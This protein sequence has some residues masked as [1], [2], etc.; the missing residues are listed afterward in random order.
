[1]ACFADINVSQG[2]VAT[3][4]RSDGIFNTSLTTNLPRNLP[5]KKKQF[6]SVKI[7]QNYGHESVAPLF[8]PILY[9]IVLHLFLLT[10]YICVFILSGCIY[11][12]MNYI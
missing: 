5:V 11:C 7:W 2:S 8:W 4:T 9:N 3:E 10:S 6:K 12:E 1:M